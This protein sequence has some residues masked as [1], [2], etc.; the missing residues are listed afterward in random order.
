MVELC[1]TTRRISN[2]KDKVIYGCRY[3]EIVGG[4]VLANKIN[5]FFI[6][7]TSE[8]TPLQPESVA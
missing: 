1:K 5:D 6:S 7:I 2:E 4:E 3:N 8:I